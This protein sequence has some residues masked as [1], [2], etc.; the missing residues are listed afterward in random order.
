MK[1]DA[2]CRL[3]HPNAHLKDVALFAWIFFCANCQAGPG[4]KEAF[5][6]AATEP[7]TG[8]RG[9]GAS[10]DMAARLALR[11]HLRHSRGNNTLP[12]R[13]FSMNGPH[14]STRFDWSHARGNSMTVRST[15]IRRQGLALALAAVFAIPALHVAIAQDAA[16]PTAVVARANGI[17]IT[18]ADIAIAAEDPS[19]ALPDMGEEQ[20]RGIIIG[21]LIDLKL[22]AQAAAEAQVS[23]TEDF[24]RRLGYFRDKLLLDDYLQQRV[25]AAVTDE[26]ARALYDE[27]LAAVEPEDEVRAR[28]ILVAEEAEANAIVE[29]LEAGED[30]AA[31]AAEASQ[32]P[33]S[34]TQGGDL[35]FFTRER[36]VAP[37]A[38]KAFELEPGQT[39]EPVQT[40]FGWHII[41]VEERRERPIPG[42]D[43]MRP[44]IDSYLARRAQQETILTLRQEAEIERLDAPADDAPTDDAPAAD[45]APEAPEQPAAPQ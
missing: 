42:F 16:D 43:E 25:E 45:D 31:I 3:N 44:Q 18:E 36:M 23:E 9:S 24:Q 26:A 6:E 2:R 11:A 27:T 8:L 41:R 32:D 40:Q 21:Y 33:G 13:S 10:A 30:F 28:H 17:E 14:F 15:S 5:G 20:R 7:R 37:F 34:R 38:E 39:S 35:G 29:R 1:R 22:G 4:A 19:L 12:Q